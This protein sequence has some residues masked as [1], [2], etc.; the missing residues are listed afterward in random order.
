MVFSWS[1]AVKTLDVLIGCGLFRVESDM[2]S[3]T[4]FG[5]YSAQSL[6]GTLARSPRSLTAMDS[7]LSMRPSTLVGRPVYKRAMTLFAKTGFWIDLIEIIKALSACNLVIGADFSHTRKSSTNFPNPWSDELNSLKNLTSRLDEKMISI[8]LDSLSWTPTSVVIILLI[9][10]QTWVTV[11][12]RIFILSLISVLRVSLK[13]SLASI[14]LKVVGKSDSFS[15]P[16]WHSR[17]NLSRLESKALTTSF[18]ISFLKISIRA[19]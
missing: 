16:S 7:R 12:D 19:P 10:S 11:D 13:L 4:D 1:V 14:I 9:W 17:L 5:A 2:F 6:K 18:V 8:N 3:T 15:I